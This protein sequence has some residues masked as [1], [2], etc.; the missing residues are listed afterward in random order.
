MHLNNLN[1]LRSTRFFAEKNSSALKCC[2][3]WKSLNVLPIAIYSLIKN[4]KK[5][6]AK[7]LYVHLKVFALSF[8]VLKH[9]N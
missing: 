5:L 8:S 9:C 2:K 3:C 4:L 1:A 6:R 7:T